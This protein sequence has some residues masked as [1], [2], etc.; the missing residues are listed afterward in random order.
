MNVRFYRGFRGIWI[1]RLV[2]LFFQ[3]PYQFLSASVHPT[4]QWR[5]A[6]T[7]AALYLVLAPFDAEVSDMLQRIKAEKKLADLPSCERAYALF[8]THEL[9]AW[10]L[11]FDGEW[12]AHAVFQV[13]VCV[14][15][16]RVI[17]LSSPN[18]EIKFG[19]STA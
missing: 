19:S 18:Q 1:C 16:F 9:C 12:R 11:P 14:N 4:H 2:A 3:Y 8:T 5:D 13:C 6:L 17:R 15:I 10:P 7:H